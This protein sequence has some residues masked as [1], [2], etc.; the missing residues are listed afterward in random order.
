MFESL[1]FR[2]NA[3]PLS[4]DIWNLF[5]EK[6]MEHT[7]KTKNP[8]NILYTYIWQSEDHMVRRSCKQQ[9]KTQ[10]VERAAGSRS[11]D[12]PS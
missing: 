3:F 6:S 2:S 12:V 9:F 10:T 4:I 1:L 5:H 7:H 8:K 11:P